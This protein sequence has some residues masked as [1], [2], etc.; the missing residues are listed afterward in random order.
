M[1][2]FLF[3]LSHDLMTLLHE[4]FVLARSS[5]PVVQH[6]DGS[7]SVQSLTE[8]KEFK[9]AQSTELFGRLLTMWLYGFLE[10]FCKGFGG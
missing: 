10:T 3:D 9:N 1:D 7:F 5:C 6:V 2:S 8:F 4:N